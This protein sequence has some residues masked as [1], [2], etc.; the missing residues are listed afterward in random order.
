MKKIYFLFIICSYTY[1][2]LAQNDSIIPKKE[3]NI[4][5]RSVL[6]YINIKLDLDSNNERFDLTGPNFEYDIRPNVSTTSRLSVN[7]LFLSASVTYIPKFFP[8]NNDNDLKGKTKGV[9]FGLNLNF[10]HWIQELKYS[11]V[12]GFYLANSNEYVSPWIEGTTP[13]VQ[14]PDLKVISFRGSTGYKFNPNFSLKA[15]SSQTEI[16]LKSAGSFIPGLLYSY[17]I[18]DN[19]SD[20][21]NQQS[22]QRSKSFEILANIG[23]YY[24]FVL[25]K[26]WYTSVGISPSAGI[27]YTDL[28]TRFP[29]EQIKTNYSS[30]VFRINGKGGLGYNA[31][32]LFGGA[33]ITAYK[34]FRDNNDPTI[35]VATT[36]IAFQVF[37]GYRF[38]SPEKVRTFMEKVEAKNP[39]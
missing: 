37:I 32:R 16:Q 25:H 34:S 19:Q 20:S 15:I 26:S 21:E 10:D 13:Y 2:T 7:Y 5:Y 27:N 33:E 18:I 8:G 17:Y 29:D 38:K 31:E 6:D 39:L 14:F 11:K 22:S 12:K 23:Y 4:Y 36:N 30:G 9:G 35:N 3:P 28:L 1:P 24:T